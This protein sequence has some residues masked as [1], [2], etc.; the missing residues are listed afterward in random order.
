MASLK[1]GFL[2]AGKMATALGKG[3]INAKLVKAGQLVAA[4][5]FAAAREHFAAETGAKMLLFPP[6]VGGV[7][8]I[9]TYFDLFDY[10]LNLLKNSLGGATK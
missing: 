10:D 8:E 3:F 2:G 4:D 9:K 5:P 6:S 1:I 7:K